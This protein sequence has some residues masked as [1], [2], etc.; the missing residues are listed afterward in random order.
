MASA[1]FVRGKRRFRSAS[2]LEAGLARY[3]MAV[4]AACFVRF[5]RAHEDHGVIVVGGLAVDD[6]L[7]A[8][9]F[10]T[11]DHADGV[12]LVNIFSLRRK[13]RHGVERLPTEVEI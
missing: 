5:L 8:G 13:L 6:A 3:L 2:R 7:G 12:E 1:P 11:A 10:V 4:P 9:R